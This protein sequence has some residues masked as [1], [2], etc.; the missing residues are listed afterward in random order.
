MLAPCSPASALAFSLHKH[1]T[2]APPATRQS[3]VRTPSTGQ[4]HPSS[5]S[6]EKLWWCRSHFKHRVTGTTAR[7]ETRLGTAA[8]RAGKS[9]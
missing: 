4:A 2:T 6:S 3:I 1:S 9:L 8:A 7:H 5:N